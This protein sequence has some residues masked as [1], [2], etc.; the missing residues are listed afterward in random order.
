M[1]DTLILMAYGFSIAT[2]L[3]ITI[4]VL[5]A[6]VKTLFGLL[7]PFVELWRP[8]PSIIFIPVI[9]LYAGLGRPMNVLVI[10]IAATEPV[11]LN[12]FGGARSITP[13]LLN[14]AATFRL[15][16]WQTLREIVLPSAA[17]QIL[18]GL[19]LAL[20]KSLVI[21]VGSGMIAGDSGIGFYVVTAQQ[22]LDIPKMFAGAFT[23]ALV[24]YAL[25]AVFVLTERRFL[26]WHVGNNAQPTT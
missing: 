9:I 3:G 13:V 5:M 23:V 20:A 8:I 25:N 15:T 1:L 21:A 18:V 24:G 19:R 11:I 6:R 17:P 4:G 14:T 2:V 22:T 26:H 12:A 10:V 7:E 16:W